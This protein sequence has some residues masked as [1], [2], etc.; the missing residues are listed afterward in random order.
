MKV[1]YSSL[2]HPKHL[3]DFIH[4]AEMLQAMQLSELVVRLLGMCLDTNP[5][6]IITEYH[7]LGSADKIDNILAQGDFSDMNTLRT[8][9]QL[10]LDYARILS[11]L[12]SSPVG[13]RI[14]CDSNSSHKALS[15]FLI[16]NDL[17]LV[18]NDL[19]ALPLVDSAKG[20]L[21]KCGHRQLYGDFVAPEQLWPFPY[22]DFRDEDMPTYDE[23]TD[24]WKVPDITDALLGD[25]D[26]SD[27]I[28]LHLFKIHR[29]CKESD[30][31][32]RPTAEEIYKVYQEIFD[33]IVID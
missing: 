7:E 10:C 20:I 15:Q 12:H 3:E 24:I 22:K 11:F 9:F 17:R 32:L 2:T 31:T 33:S 25:V 29:R 14:M 13:T 27:I 26:H 19:D 16:T 28:R 30:P 5:P 21:A 1:A 18:I 6:T 23:K 4:G 8:R